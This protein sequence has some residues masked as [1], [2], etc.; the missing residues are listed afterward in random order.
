MLSTIFG[1]I[2]SA[3]LDG[4][5]VK[6]RQWVDQALNLDNVGDGFF[7]RADR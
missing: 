4:T 1:P 2:V 5:E 7:L 3:W 6:M